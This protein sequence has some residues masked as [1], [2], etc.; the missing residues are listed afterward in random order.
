MSL[1]HF[2]RLSRS[3]K[4]ASETASQEA[5]TKAQ[6]DAALVVNSVGV[7]ST[8]KRGERSTAFSTAADALGDAIKAAREAKLARVRDDKETDI[9]Q[10]KAAKSLAELLAESAQERRISY[11]VRSTQ[12][13][14][15]RTLYGQRGGFLLFPAIA[16]TIWLGVLFPYPKRWSANA[17][18][19][20]AEP[21]SQS[22]WSFQYPFCRK[23]GH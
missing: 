9:E 13:A 3:I 12:A 11:P 19:R 10:P 15:F 17:L 4:D 20:N 21:P 22:S 23:R 14:I 5:T 2:S 7:Q 16:D 1:E 6:K 18:S 8:P